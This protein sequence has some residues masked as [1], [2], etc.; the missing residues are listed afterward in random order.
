DFV[1]EVLLRRFRAVAVVVGDN[2]RFGHRAAG[3]SETLAELGEK[4]GFVVDAEPLVTGEGGVWSSTYVRGLVRAGDVAS[5][6]Y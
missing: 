1:D 4:H 5:A 6:A 3:D 2:F